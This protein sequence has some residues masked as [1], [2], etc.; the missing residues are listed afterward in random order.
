MTAA[1]SGDFSHPTGQDGNV[2]FLW[3]LCWKHGLLIQDFRE[4][5]RRNCV[6]WKA[7]SWLYWAWFALW[8]LSV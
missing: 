8:V 6:N 2:F 3:S 1:L 5:L 4:T 7:Y